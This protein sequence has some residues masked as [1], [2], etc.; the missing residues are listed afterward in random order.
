MSLIKSM[1]EDNNDKRYPIDRIYTSKLVR[2]VNTQ[3]NK[4]EKL[5]Y[6]QEKYEPYNVL[7]KHET[8]DI[9]TDIETGERFTLATPTVINYDKNHNNHKM[10]VSA[11]YKT[12]FK[13]TCREELKRYDIAH[14][15][16]LS[17]EQF[18]NMLY[19]EEVKWGR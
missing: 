1:I 9:Y 2:F 16:Y 6:V 11:K 17:V 7:L 8:A 5:Y 14:T 18:R 3:P 10:Y 15:E 12:P 13:M 4:L 19:E